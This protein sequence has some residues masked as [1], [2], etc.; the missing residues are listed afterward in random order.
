MGGYITSSAFRKSGLAGFAK[1]HFFVVYTSCIRSSFCQ[2]CLRLQID[3]VLDA[4][5][6]QP[7]AERYISM[8][9]LLNSPN[10][11]FKHFF[12]FLFSCSCFFLFVNLK[13]FSFKIFRFQAACS[14]V[15]SGNFPQCCWI[16]ETKDF[17]RKN[18]N[19]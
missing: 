15:S 2:C 7:N 5:A 12:V 16:K 8:L 11:F 3:V 14:N 1:P 19:N 18:E 17:D 13:S 9:D 6:N 10:I 4:K